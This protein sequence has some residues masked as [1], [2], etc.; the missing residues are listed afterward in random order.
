MDMPEQESET[1]FERFKRYTARAI[2]V[3]RTEIQ[4]RELKWKNDRKKH[5]T[6]KRHR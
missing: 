5:K 1:P 3:P 4:K 6:H 2:S